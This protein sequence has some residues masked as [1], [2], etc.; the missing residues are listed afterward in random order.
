MSARIRLI[1]GKAV[2]S[3]GKEVEFYLDPMSG[4]QQWGAS[5]E[6]LSSTCVLMGSL[7]EASREHFAGD[8]DEQH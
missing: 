8:D 2:L 7:Y 5:A 1:T 6:V 3:D 4:W